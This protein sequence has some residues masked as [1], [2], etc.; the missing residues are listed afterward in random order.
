MISSKT[1]KIITESVKSADD[2]FIRSIAPSDATS[3]RSAVLREVNSVMSK[4]A[5]M[6]IILLK[7]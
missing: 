7:H 2:A 6:T 3:Q 1:L 4:S 5:N